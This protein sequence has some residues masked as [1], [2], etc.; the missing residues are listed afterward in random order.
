MCTKSRRGLIASAAYYEG[1]RISVWDFVNNIFLMCFTTDKFFQDFRD[2]LT[3]EILIHSDS[4]T[5]DA[6]KN[7]AFILM[8]FGRNSVILFFT[9]SNSFG[10]YS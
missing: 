7:D 9:R 6:L 2:P 10:T 3:F 8:D 5:W 1:P 4:G